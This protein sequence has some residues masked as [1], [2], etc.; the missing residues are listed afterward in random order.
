M[1]R[2]ERPF[3][4]TCFLIL[5]FFFFSFLVYYWFDRGVVRKPSIE[6]FSY[7]TQYDYMP[8]RTVKNLKLTYGVQDLVEE[9]VSAIGFVKVHNRITDVS[10]SVSDGYSKTVAQL[11]ISSDYT[12]ISNEYTAQMNKT[13][14]SYFDPKKLPTLTEDPQFEKNWQIAVAPYA[15]LY[16]KVVYFGMNGA[17]PNARLFETYFANLLRKY[18][19]NTTQLNA[20]QTFFYNLVKPVFL[21]NALLSLYAANTQRYTNKDGE[22]AVRFLLNTQLDYIRKMT[23]TADFPHTDSSGN[24]YIFADDS[25]N[26]SNTTFSLD[27]ITLYQTV[28][29]ATS[30][31]QALLSHSV[32]PLSMT[33]ST[34]V[35]GFPTYLKK[36]YPDNTPVSTWIF[37]L[38][39]PPPEST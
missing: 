4:V 7:N 21:Q 24:V 22:D 10:N 13:F 30:F 36:L 1:Q 8:S 38:N 18:S 14:A 5:L 28:S 37:V 20:I 12:A 26:V 2:I 23:V 35:S 6:P 3:F 34:F 11:A 33:A 15:T 29:I 19:T 17:N 25:T 27:S 16:N 39:N 32:S 9:T 31:W